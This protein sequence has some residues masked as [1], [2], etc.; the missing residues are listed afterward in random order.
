MDASDNVLRG[1]LTTKPLDVDELLVVLDPMAEPRFLTAPTAGRL[2]TSTLTASVYRHAHRSAYPAP[3]F[4]WC[5][6]GPI[7]ATGPASMCVDAG[8]TFFVPEEA[9]SFTLAGGAAWVVAGPVATHDV[10]P[11]PVGAHP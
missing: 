8:A 6:D 7:D 11:N 10:P 5:T 3:A 4:V 2:A 9:G 1:G